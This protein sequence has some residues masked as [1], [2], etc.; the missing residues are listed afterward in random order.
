MSKNKISNYPVGNYIHNECDYEYFLNQIVEQF[1]HATQLFTTDVGKEY[2]LFTQFLGGLSNDAAT[3]QHYN[4]NACRSFVN[5]YG[6]LVWIDPNYNIVPAIWPDPSKVPGMYQAAVNVCREIILSQTKVTGVFYTDKNVL[7]T[8]ITGEWTHMAAKVPSK[9]IHDRL[10]LN[11]YQAMAEKKEDFKSLLNGIH[12]YSIDVM[13]EALRLLKTDS[14]FRSEK[15]LGVAKWLYNVFTL[16]KSIKNSR[17]RNNMLWSKVASAPAGFCH[18]KSNVLSPLLNDIINGASYRVMAKKFESK[19]NPDEYQRPQEAP[20]EGTKIQA[21]K[22]V[23]KMGIRKSFQRRFAS[24][25]DI[26]T[27][28]CPQNIKEEEIENSGLFDKV[29]TK[30]GAPRVQKVN[31]PAQHIT[32]VKFRSKVLGSADSIRYYIPNCPGNYTA[33]VTAVDPEAPPIIQWDSKECRNPVSYYLY[34][35]GSWPQQWN[36]VGDTICEVTGIANLPHMWSGKN[37]SHHK[38]GVILLL[39]GAK[40][41]RNPGLAL[42]PEILRKELHGVR[43]VI[44]SYSNQEKLAEPESPPACGVLFSGA[45]PVKLKVTSDGDTM[46]YIIDRWD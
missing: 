17:L 44:E 2:D 1:S 7:G 34:T 6:G 37:F 19:L 3:R 42:F 5:K 14:L 18:V 31:I 16:N 26:F 4:C 25:E 23:E 10:D 24:V 8:P 38:E 28:W 45:Y 32:W 39:K 15:C 13:K 9:L 43:S 41:Q 30:D 40:D 29:V 35:N 21:E 36:L 12:E 11:C 27:I 22:L 20:S 46:D 33:F